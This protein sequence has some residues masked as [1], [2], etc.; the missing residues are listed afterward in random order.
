MIKDL[1]KFNRDLKNIVIW[2][3]KVKYI[4]YVKESIENEDGVET[5]VLHILDKEG[6]TYAESWEMADHMDDFILA[7]A[8]EM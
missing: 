8:S 7:I 2:I 6:T 5:I 1:T 3:L 4:D